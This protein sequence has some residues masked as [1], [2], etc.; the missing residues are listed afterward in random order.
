[1]FR[2]TLF[3]PFDLGHR[4]LNESDQLFH[5]PEVIGATAVDMLDTASELRR[6]RAR[7]LT[8]LDHEGPPHDGEDKRHP[9][10]AA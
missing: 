1:V 3:R 6:P 10:A 9:A 8:K 2:F 7:V 4:S 5:R